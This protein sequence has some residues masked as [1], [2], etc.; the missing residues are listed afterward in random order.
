MSLRLRGSF[1]TVP[2]TF[3]QL[4]GLSFISAGLEIRWSSQYLQGVFLTHWGPSIKTFHLF[5]KSV[6]HAHVFQQRFS[7]NLLSNY[8]P[9]Y[10]AQNPEPNLLFI[11]HLFAFSLIK[12]LAFSFSLAK[13]SW[14]CLHFIRII[15]MQWIHK[16]YEGVFL[17]HARVY[18]VVS[19]PLSCSHLVFLR[20]SFFIFLSSLS[21]ALSFFLVSLFLS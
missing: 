5:L 9:E 15:L 3:L 11:T 17:T 7:T 12:Y 4:G 18:V 13:L 2:N 21:L 8:S 16:R 19:L 6:A 10:R 20:L 14:H 1:N